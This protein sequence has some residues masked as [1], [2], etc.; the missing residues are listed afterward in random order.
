MSEENCI[1]NATLSSPDFIL[2]CARWTVKKN[3]SSAFS[4]DLRYGIL[5]PHETEG[6]M[7]L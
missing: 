2:C 4:V 1:L 7:N 3:G 6:G 5:N